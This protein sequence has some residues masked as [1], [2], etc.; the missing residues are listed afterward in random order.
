MTLNKAE[1]KELVRLMETLS[2]DPDDNR[3]QS[4]G[5]DLIRIL[6]IWED[7]LPVLRQMT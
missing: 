3:F 4:K 1:E 6:Q 5:R 2:I 7:N